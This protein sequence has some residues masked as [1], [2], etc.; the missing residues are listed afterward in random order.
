M[1][2]KVW[3]DRVG[4]GRVSSMKMRT[5]ILT[6]IYVGCAPVSEFS[7]CPELL[8]EC[9]NSIPADCVGHE[10]CYVSEGIK[11]DR[12]YGKCLENKFSYYC[13][14]RYEDCLPYWND[15]SCAREFDDCMEKYQENE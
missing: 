2:E 12:E 9:Y 1:G 13:T 4:C 5:I 6:L 15:Y 11:C 14:T 3:K 7:Q 8:V 10:D